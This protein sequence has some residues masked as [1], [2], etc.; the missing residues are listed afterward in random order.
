MTIDSRH[1]EILMSDDSSVASELLVNLINDS[2]AF[3]APMKKIRIK[4]PKIEN[5]NLSK[6]TINKINSLKLQ[7][8]I[9]KH[10]NSTIEKDIYKKLK[11]EVI[12]MKDKD[13]FNEKARYLRS[14]KNE[15][16]LWNTFN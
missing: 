1:N 15:Y 9:A 11:K 3:T 4:K 14:Q 8:S 16:G 13:R 6:D 10:T 12:I 5:I 2:L 7:K